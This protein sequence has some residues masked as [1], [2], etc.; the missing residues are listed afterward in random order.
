LKP[1]GKR[2]LGNPWCRF[3]VNISGAED[4]NIYT[5]KRYI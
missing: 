1:E 3:E 5:D 4:R 2:A